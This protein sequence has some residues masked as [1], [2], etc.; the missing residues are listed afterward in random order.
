MERK[1]FNIQGIVNT[2]P[3][4][5]DMD[6]SVDVS[7]MDFGSPAAGELSDVVSRIVTITGTA[8]T[9]AL[10]IGAT[11]W[12]ASDKIMAGNN[13]EVSLDAGALVPVIV[14]G[15]VLLGNLVAGEYTLNFR[16][17]PPT[18]IDLNTYTQEIVVIGE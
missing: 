9:V 10:S 18:N 7:D 3:A 17:T 16:V 8:G 6:V 13:T 11:D 4:P 14:A 1:E 15:E 12:V 5:T 2:T